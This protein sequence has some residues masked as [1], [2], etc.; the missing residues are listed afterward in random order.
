MYNYGRLRLEKLFAKVT[1]F[2]SLITLAL[3]LGLLANNA[4]NKTASFAIALIM[5]LTYLVY[6]AVVLAVW[7]IED[8][9]EILSKE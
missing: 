7:R 1:I 9:N 8:I 3:M 4:T 6:K 5:F 2:A